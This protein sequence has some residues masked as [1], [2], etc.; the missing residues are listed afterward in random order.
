MAL[1]LPHRPLTATDLTKLPDDGHRYEL[2]DGTLLV[3][4]APGTPHQ[5][6]LG[7]L[8]T[9]LDTQLPP[10]LTVLPA[11]YDWIINPN[12]VVQ[13]DLLV[14]HTAD[15]G[16]HHLQATPVVVIEILSPSTRRT[17]QGTKRLTYQDAGVP[18][19]WL[20][21]PEEPV[22]LTVL[23]LDDAGTYQTTATATSDT[24]HTDHGLGI[25]LTPSALLN[26]RR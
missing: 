3:T 14:A 11:P 6:C 7:R 24:A 20:L 22:T 12:T 19:Y 26:P 1:A 9:L 5:I 8:Y 16:P 17:D 23:Q 25:T 2:I 4:P 15:L 18:T 21:D 10:E 13:P